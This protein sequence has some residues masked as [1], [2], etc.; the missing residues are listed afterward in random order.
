MRLT[1]SAGEVISDAPI[2]NLEGVWPS[3]IL[4]SITSL[5]MA[6]DEDGLVAAPTFDTLS[7][8]CLLFDVV[9]P[10]TVDLVSCL[11]G[12]LFT[13]NSSDSDSLTSHSL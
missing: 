13:F 10:A 6:V 7:T 11:P 3:T 1:K 5:L 2:R 4:A 8:V 12:R 9:S